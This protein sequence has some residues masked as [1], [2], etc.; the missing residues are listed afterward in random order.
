V[1]RKDNTNLPALSRQ[2]FSSFSGRGLRICN[3]PGL[4]KQSAGRERRDAGVAGRPCSG[5]ELVER[6][7]EGSESLPGS[8]GRRD[9]DVLPRSDPRPGLLLDVRGSADPLFKPP[10]DEGVKMG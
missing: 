3:Q 5:D 2:K 6:V 10:G 9:E 1:P 7:Q 4:Q 8:R